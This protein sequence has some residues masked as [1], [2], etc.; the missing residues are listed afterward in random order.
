MT[1]VTRHAT[2]V[3]A[4]RAPRRRAGMRS[5][6]TSIT[7]GGRRACRGVVLETFENSGKDELRDEVRLRLRQAAAPHA[8]PSEGCV[9][10]GDVDRIAYVDAIALPRF[11]D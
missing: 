6:R 2:C 8:I 7:E 3:R 4:T 1:S 10:H 9:A 11:E 5:A